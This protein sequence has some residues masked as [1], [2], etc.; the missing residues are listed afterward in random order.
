MIPSLREATSPA[1]PLG[2]EV[3][4]ATRESKAPAKAE[5]DRSVA[6]APAYLA[7]VLVHY[8]RRHLPWGLARLVRGPGA[9]QDVPGLRFARVLGSGRDG[10]FVASPSWRHQGLMAFFDDASQATDFL[11]HHPAVQGRRQRSDTC[12]TGL[13]A[14]ISSR[15]SWD[16]QTLQPASR[17]TCDAQ[18]TDGVRRPVHP[19]TANQP[20]MPVAA[21]TRATLNPRHAVTFWRHSPGSEQALARASGCQLAAGLGE[22]PLLRQATFSL[23]DSPEAMQAYARRGAH[24][25]AARR[26]W[27]Q[28]WFR[29]WMFARLQPLWLQGEW[30]GRRFDA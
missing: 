11:R 28:G 10:G 23:W 3:A 20:A 19:A 17:D 24:G 8:Q 21:L 12:L 13:F 22:R 29:E 4:F 5:P 7:L 1:T 2:G 25:D 14:T 26:A 30:K 15:G 9:L 27:Q 18:A 6:A 16:G